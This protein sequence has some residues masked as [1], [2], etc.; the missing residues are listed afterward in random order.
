MDK[1]KLRKMYKSLG[2]CE[3]EIQKYIKLEE[4]SGQAYF[5]A[6][7]FIRPL[8]N[9]VKEYRSNQWADLQRERIAKGIMEE[10]TSDLFIMELKNKGVDLNELSQFIADIIATAYNDVLYRISDS[11][12]DDYDL[13][14]GGMGLP[15]WTLKERDEDG[16]ETG[17]VLPELH[18]LIEW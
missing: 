14:Y 2:Y 13:P 1:E 12:G 4:E 9:T 10:E 18:N 17:R 7:R 5:S 15:D 16:E 6:I 8:N 11:E 3:E